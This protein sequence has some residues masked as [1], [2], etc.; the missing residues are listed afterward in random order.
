MNY[1]MC[2]CGEDRRGRKI[3]IRWHAIMTICDGKL[4]EIVFYA[5]ARHLT[6]MRS[7]L[8]SCKFVKFD[9]IDVFCLTCST[10]DDQAKD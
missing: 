1:K 8:L 5:G 2:L 3:P 10:G 4:I 6:E 7:V 9:I